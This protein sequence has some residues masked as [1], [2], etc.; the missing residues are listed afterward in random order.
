[1][2]F[3]NNNKLILKT[4]NQCK[5]FKIIIKK[6]IITILILIIMKT[7]VYINNNKN[8]IKIRLN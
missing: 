2:Q 1:M 3:L 6:I 4:I 7:N 5:N 8:K